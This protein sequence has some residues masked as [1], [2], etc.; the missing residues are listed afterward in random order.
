VVEGAQ[1]RTVQE[2]LASLT[3]T[4]SLEC[5]GRGG[6]QG[7]TYSLVRDPPHD[8]AEEN[9]GTRGS[10]GIA[11]NADRAIESPNLQE[12]LTIARSRGGDSNGQPQ[13]EAREP[14][15]EDAVRQSKGS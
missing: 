1:P 3:S 2:V 8:L 4:G 7:Y 6:S 11:R 13:E 12:D 5:D 10:R 14:D 9:E 15:E